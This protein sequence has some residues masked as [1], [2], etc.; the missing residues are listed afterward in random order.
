[1]GQQFIRGLQEIKLILFFLVKSEDQA[2]GPA[3]YLVYVVLFIVYKKVSIRYWRYCKPHQ[4]IVCNF[5]DIQT[6]FHMK[7]LKQIAC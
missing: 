3:L 2:A 7:I 4:Y 1:M 6:L 5:T